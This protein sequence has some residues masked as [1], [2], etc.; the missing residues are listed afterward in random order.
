[1]PCKNGSVYLT[2]RKRAPFGRMRC[3]RVLD[4]SP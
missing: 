2:E 3:M 1:M 4:L